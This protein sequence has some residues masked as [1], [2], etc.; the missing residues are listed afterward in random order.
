MREREGGREGGR[1]GR[2]VGGTEYERRRRRKKRTEATD[3]G[4]WKKNDGGRE[5]VGI[6]ATRPIEYQNKDVS[7]QEKVW[8]GCGV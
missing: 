5:L 4:V 3:Q 2:E 6:G 8:W 1:G 7:N